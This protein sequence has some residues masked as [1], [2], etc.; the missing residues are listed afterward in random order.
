MKV[1]QFL[2]CCTE[3]SLN[4]TISYTLYDDKIIQSFQES[5]DLPYDECL[6][7]LKALKTYLWL[8]NKW[9]TEYDSIFKPPEV[10]V[11]QE[12]WRTFILLTKEYYVFSYKMF[13]KYLH[14]NAQN[15]SA[16]VYEW[17]MNLFEKAHIDKS[18]LE[19]WSFIW[20]IKYSEVRMKSIYLRKY[21]IQAIKSV[22]T[23]VHISPLVGVYAWNS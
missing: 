2:E 3:T 21:H 15:E 22:T 14:Y 18:I 20:D 4:D 8:S 7:I 12:M 19:T 23:D 5:Y 6:N 1:L 16:K 13:N 9:Y 17:E 10:F 11:I